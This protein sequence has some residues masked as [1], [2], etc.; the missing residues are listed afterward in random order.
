M[1]STEG[2]LAIIGIKTIK[3][4]IVGLAEGITATPDLPPAEITAGMLDV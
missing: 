4:L 3:I 1:T 2:T